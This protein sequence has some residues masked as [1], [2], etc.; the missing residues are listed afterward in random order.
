MRVE[1]QCIVDVDRDTVWKVV[2]S[3]IAIQSSWRVSSAGEMEEDGPA[4]LG[5]RYTVHW[6]VGSVPIGGV[7]E[8][9]E[10]R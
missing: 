1:R 7:I 4:T 3:P 6:K 9:I 2:S 5:A 10:F 8:V